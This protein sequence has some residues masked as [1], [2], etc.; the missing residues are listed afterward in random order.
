MLPRK[1][2]IRFSSIIRAVGLAG[3]LLLLLPIAL[4]AE[5]NSNHVVCRDEVTARNV[6]G[7]SI[8]AGDAVLALGIALDGCQRLADR[9]ESR[10]SRTLATA[11]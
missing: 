10:F 5:Q 1:C 3:I 6:L 7:D 8:V 2:G 9:L 4:Q 11:S